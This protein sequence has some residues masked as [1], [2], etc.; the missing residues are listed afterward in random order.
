[1]TQD[2]MTGR[3]VVL[4]SDVV[5][6]GDGFDDYGYDWAVCHAGSWIQW[7]HRYAWVAGRRQHHRCPVRWVKVN[8]KLGYVPIHPRDARRQG[9]GQSEARNLCAGGAEGRRAWSEWPMIRERNEVAGGGTREFREPT[10]PTLRATSAPRAEAR[11]PAGGL[12][13]SKARRRPSMIAFDSRRRGD[14]R[15]QRRSMRADEATWW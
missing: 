7:R 11:Q 5:W 1:M 3:T 14:L 8:G 13:G 10:L 6:N 15:S 4:A 9:A 12:A 2:P